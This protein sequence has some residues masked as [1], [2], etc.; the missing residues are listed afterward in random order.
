MKRSC[1]VATIMSSRCPRRLMWHDD[2]N[3]PIQNDRKSEGTNGPCGKF[4][5]KSPI[6]MRVDEAGSGSERPT[7]STPMITK[8]RRP[9]QAVPRVLEVRGVLQVREV[10]EVR[11]VRGVRKVREVL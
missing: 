1:C 6:R 7:A 3:P 10:L 8:P 9:R 4:M 2:S 5:A 11:G